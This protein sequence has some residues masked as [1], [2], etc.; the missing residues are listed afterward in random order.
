MAKFKRH[1]PLNR[2]APPKKNKNKNKNESIVFLDSHYAN[3]ER[4]RNK[5]V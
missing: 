3:I 1:D 5:N 4:K 2:K